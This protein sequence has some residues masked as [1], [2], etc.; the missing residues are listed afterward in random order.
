MEQSVILPS[1]I[2]I[3]FSIVFGVTMP[4]NKIQDVLVES[5]IWVYRKRPIRIAPL[6]PGVIPGH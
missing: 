3:S 1:D 2:A 6:Q 5:L 4:S